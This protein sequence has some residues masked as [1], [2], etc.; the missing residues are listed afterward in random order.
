M[1]DGV[2][3]YANNRV[4]SATNTNTPAIRYAKNVFFGAQALMRGFAQ[5]PDR[6]EEQFDYGRQSGVA[7]TMI[8]GDPREGAMI[9]GAARQALSGLLP[10]DKE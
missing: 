9:A 4:P 1:W 10:G 7:T 5:Y 6:R 2:I 3:L 8:K